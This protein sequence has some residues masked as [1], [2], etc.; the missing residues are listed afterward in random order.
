MNKARIL[1]VGDDQALLETR[2]LILRDWETTKAKSTEALSSIHT[3]SFDIIIV[4]Q[5]VSTGLALEMASAA[6][7]LNPPAHV[8]AVRFPEDDSD[9][10]VETHATDLG[11]HPSWLRERV[12]FLLAKR[13]AAD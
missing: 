13:S 2:A 3:G 1:L 10:G 9:L 6:K 11:V 8:I 7:A 4:G 5:T 12:A